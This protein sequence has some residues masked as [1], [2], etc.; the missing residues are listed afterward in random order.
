MGSE[1]SRIGGEIHRRSALRSQAASRASAGAWAVSGLVS[2]AGPAV[3]GRMLFCRWARLG[4]VG[5]LVAVFSAGAATAA[6]ADR[7]DRLTVAGCSLPNHTLAEALERLHA[8]G[9]AG[10]EIATFADNEK[11][12]APDSAPWVVV[13]RLAPEEKR[14]LREAAGKFRHVSVHLPYGQ[15]VRPLAPEAAVREATRR[16][17]RRALDDGAFLGARLANVHVLTEPGLAFAAALPELVRLYRELGDE[18]ATRGM[19]LAI[20]ITRPYT[21]ADYLALIRAVA[22]PNVGGSIDTGHVHFFAELADARKQRQTPEAVRAYND[23]LHDLV[24]QLGPKLFHV[25]LDDVR[26]VDWR[27]HFVPGTGIIDWPRFFG[28]L[29]AVDYRGLLVL[30]L[31]YYVGADDTGASITRAF[32]ER[33]P[34]GAA[35]AG[36]EAARAHLAPLIGP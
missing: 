5:L 10:V 35:V 26:R 14:R 18:A 32:R 20:E 34:D 8:L 27:E 2:R 22:H 7:L 16:E 24:G 11:T 13:D 15:T 29:R 3:A 9:F 28:A 23:L 17:L 12:N 30:E 21:A 25:H 36:L 19:R 33:T 4:L 31:L 1:A 6:P